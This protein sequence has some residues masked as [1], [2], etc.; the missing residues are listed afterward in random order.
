MRGVTVILKE[1]TQTGTDAFGQPVYET[2][3]V[4]IDDVL[5]GRPESTDIQNTLSLYGKKITYTLSIPKGDTHVWYKSQVV[6]PAPWNE[7]FNVIGDA[8]ETI[9]AN[10]P[11][12]WNRVVHLERIDG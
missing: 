7:T 10:T 11:T 12:R 9:E 8:I 6:L 4:P 3:D 1:K 5:V 2:T